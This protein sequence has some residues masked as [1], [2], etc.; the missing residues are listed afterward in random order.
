[1]PASPDLLSV[2]FEKQHNARVADNNE[3]H[4]K[5]FYFF[6]GSCRFAFSSHNGHRHSAKVQDSGDFCA[7]PPLRMGALPDHI[8][9]V[10]VVKPHPTRRRQQSHPSH[11]LGAG[12]RGFDGFMLSWIAPIVSSVAA[13]Q[14]RSVFACSRQLSGA[15][16][17]N[18][19]RSYLMMDTYAW[20]CNEEQ[21]WV[22]QSF[23]GK[24]LKRREG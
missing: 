10:L 24:W 5:S 6:G 7:Y 22:K 21:D 17:L 16:S 9:F 20:L 11:Q 3:N 1:M 15:W 4:G 2:N 14:L 23:L 8:T 18:W 13:A 12:G 19:F